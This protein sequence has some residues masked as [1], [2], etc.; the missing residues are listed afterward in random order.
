MKGDTV[1]FEWKGAACTA[2][3]QVYPGYAG[4]REAPPE[5]PEMEIR[6]LEIEGTDVSF[7]LNFDEIL[8]SV[9]QAI[10][11][12]LNAQAEKDEDDGYEGY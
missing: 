12:A 4:S 6:K 10:W 7:L 1:V 9:D 3:I 11:D 5:N 2:E 8:E